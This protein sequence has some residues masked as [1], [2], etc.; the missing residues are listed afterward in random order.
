MTAYQSILQEGEIK[1]EIKGKL[2]EKRMG[3]LKALKRGKLTLNEIAE[4]FEVTVDF[5]LKIKIENELTS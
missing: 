2:E 1:G 3:I 4:D 5:V